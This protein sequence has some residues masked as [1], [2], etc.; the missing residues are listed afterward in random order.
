[1]EIHLLV[2]NIIFSVMQYYNNRGFNISCFVYE[3][4]VFMS[5]H[6]DASWLWHRFSVMK[7][8]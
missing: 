3:C 6:T 8:L 5:K 7:G 4:I 1:V 2:V